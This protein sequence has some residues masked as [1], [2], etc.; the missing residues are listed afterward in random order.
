RGPEFES[1]E[2]DPAIDS[3]HCLVAI[4]LDGDGD[5]DGATCSKDPGGHAAWYENDGRGRF[6]RH[7]IGTDQGSYD[8]RAIDMDRDKDFDLLVAGH[9]SRNI[10]WFENP[11]K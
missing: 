11:A 5:I 10:A 2:I 1:I 9:S 4:D 3:P 6:T 7:E 8:L